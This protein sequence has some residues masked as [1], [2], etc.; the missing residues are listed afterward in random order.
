MKGAYYYRNYAA[1]DVSAGTDYQGGRPSRPA[2]FYHQ[3]HAPMRVQ[4]VAI[5]SVQSFRENPQQQQ[6]RQP[7]PHN[8]GYVPPRQQQ[9]PAPVHMRHGH[10]RGVL[11]V[12][13]A[14]DVC[15]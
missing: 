6:Q 4:P 9:P 2:S 11:S 1:A 10:H 12:S 13:L 15:L 5:R 14:A 3:E 7:P 8:N